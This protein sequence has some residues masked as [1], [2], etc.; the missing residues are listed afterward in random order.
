MWTCPS[1]SSACPTILAPTTS[2]DDLVH[3]LRSW[4]SPPWLL[5]ATD[6]EEGYGGFHPP[7]T[8]SASGGGWSP[9][10]D[11]PRSTYDPP[12]DAWSFR[13]APSN[14]FTLPSNP[15][16]LSDVSLVYF[17]GRKSE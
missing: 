9:S 3:S 6:P 7:P 10:D 8:T 16:H 12:S 2:D 11:G 1:S 14:S 15:R 5:P 17:A 4:S 13:I